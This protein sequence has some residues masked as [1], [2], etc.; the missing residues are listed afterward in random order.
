MLSQV[1]DLFHGPLNRLELCGSLLHLVKRL[2]QHN[3]G[4]WE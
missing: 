3:L 4:H 2:S 1:T